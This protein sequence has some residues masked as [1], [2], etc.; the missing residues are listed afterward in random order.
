MGS[1]THL[2]SMK[3]RQGPMFPYSDGLS[4]SGKPIIIF[5]DLDDNVAKSWEV[6]QGFCSLV[7]LAAE[8]HGR[9][10]WET[11]LS[12]MNSVVYRLLDRTFDASSVNEAVRLGLLVFSTQAFLQWKLLKLAHTRL[13]TSYRVCLN[14]LRVSGSISPGLVSWLLMV[15]AISVFEQQDDSWLRPWLGETIETC[16]ITSWAE[17]QTILESFMWI[18]L[19]QE[20]PGKRVFYSVVMPQM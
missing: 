5:E 9:I 13:T 8:A 15:G 19:L 10:Q 3:Q 12:T 2:P 1:K 16:G 7:N 4:D 20:E 11:L 17:M 18:R 14:R 6:M